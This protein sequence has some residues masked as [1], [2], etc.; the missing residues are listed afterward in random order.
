[1]LVESGHLPD[2]PLLGM[3][4]VCF[5]REAVIRDA[6]GECDFSGRPL[7]HGTERTLIVRL[8]D[9]Y[10]DGIGENTLVTLDLGAE[11]Q[12]LETWMQSEPIRQ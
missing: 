6:R 12:L 3:D 9:D 5:R 10:A 11:M 4:P 1:M 8:S 2:R 7:T